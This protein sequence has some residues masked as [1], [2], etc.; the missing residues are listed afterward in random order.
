M[1]NVYNVLVSTLFDF[2]SWLIAIS[3]SRPVVGIPLLLGT[4][5]C[6]SLLVIFLF[7]RTRLTLKR[8]WDK[9][10][11]FTDHFGEID[12]RTRSLKESRQLKFSRLIFHQYIEQLVLRQVKQIYYPTGVSFAIS[13]IV[14]TSL[15]L[16]PWPQLSEVDWGK[17]IES[18][19]YQN[20]I[21]I[22]AGIGAII[23]ALLILV[24]ETSNSGK[25]SDKARFP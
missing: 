1:G 16:L 20:Y 19:F 5:A 9:A 6:F 12:L 21:A 8:I 24:A 4:I 18:N 13:L 23:L 15:F 2:F 7:H 3:Y 11:H 25:Q 14:I 17:Y 22:H 10:K